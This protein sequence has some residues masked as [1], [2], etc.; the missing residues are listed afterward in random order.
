MKILINSLGCP[1]NLVD[2]EIIANSLKE[3]CHEL[4]ADINDA[5]IAIINTCA[6]I[7][8][9]VKEAIDVI[10]K[11]SESKQNGKLKKLIV[12]GCLVE[13]YKSEILD[14]MPEVDL[15]IGID[16]YKN[17]NEL[18]NMSER[19]FICG[20]KTDSSFMNNKRLLSYNNGTAYLKIAE[21]C[22][23]HCTYC[24]IPKIRGK[25]RSRSI[26]DICAEATDLVINHGIKEITLI[27]QDTTAYGKDI[28]GKPSLNELLK[29]LEQTE[30]LLWIRLLYC[31]PELIS[32]ELIETIKNSSKI[33]HYID[34][35][36]QHASDRILKLMGRKGSY[37]KY[38][39]LIE[40]IRTQ[41]PDMIIRTTFIV[42]FPD[43]TED[44]FDILR[45]FTEEC[46]FDRAGVFEYCKEDGT[47]AARMKNQ[48]TKKSKADRKERLMLIQQK[49][50]FD[51]NNERLEKIYS[52][53]IQGVADDGIFYEGRSY[54]EAYE[55]DPL[56]Y[57]SS[58]EPL[59][60][61]QIVDVKILNTDGY[62][63]VGEVIGQ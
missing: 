26:E 46:R 31:Y 20:A 18:I 43:E 17:I 61:G 6:F 28:Y 51:K 9:A 23:N 12:T 1:K 15:C 42:G 37:D 21:G 5:E 22:D 63:I 27:A 59:E 32:D 3:A 19:T 25:Q 38:R 4:T 41:I 47:P 24:T 56:V 58:K 57:V 33:L 52:I 48:I 54:G 10:L 44:D 34:I 7:E 11:T 40:K 35:P 53:I 13:R 29:K 45:R 49:I 36:L 16:G 62:S 8:P 60:I 30:G 50:A 2:S 14:N 39:S 55:I